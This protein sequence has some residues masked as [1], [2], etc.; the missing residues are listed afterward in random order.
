MVFV[1]YD[2]IESPREHFEGLRDFSPVANAIQSG[3]NSRV[4]R[5]WYK[6]N[7]HGE[8]GTEEHDLFIRAVEPFGTKPIDRSLVYPASNLRHFGEERF[9]SE[10]RRI[11]ADASYLIGMTGIIA[12]PF[13]F[14]NN[15]V[16]FSMMEALGLAVSSLVLT[17]PSNNYHP[18]HIERFKEY[19]RTKR[20]LLRRC[21]AADEELVRALP[22]LSA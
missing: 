4:I 13:V 19:V 15:S 14:P 16:G 22:S 10:N 8:N 7:F 3:R 17:G 5:A 21:D 2:K 9:N 1:K 11:I 12:A 20:D 6:E 18:V